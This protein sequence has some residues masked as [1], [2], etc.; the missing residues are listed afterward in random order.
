MQC[1]VYIQEEARRKKLKVKIEMAKFLQDTVEEM[2]V[3][4]KQPKTQKA[5]S[6]FANFFEKVHCAL[7]VI[8]AN[9]RII[10][11]SKMHTGL[12]MHCHDT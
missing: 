5:V 4:A 12:S 9:D 6:D 2:A 1:L 10:K 3:T 11:Q 7:Y 8:M